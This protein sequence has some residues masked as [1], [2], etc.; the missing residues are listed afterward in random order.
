MKIDHIGNCIIDLEDVVDHLMAGGNLSAVSNR[1]LDFNT[2]EYNN[3]VSSKDKDQWR[4]RSVKSYDSESEMDSVCRD[5]W[6]VPDNYLD[7][8]IESYIYNLC[9]TEAEVYRV[10]QELELFKSRDLLIVLKALK[11][12]VDVMRQHRI[13]WGVGRGSS[14]ASY[15]LYLLEVHSID[16]IKYNLDFA[17]FLD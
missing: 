2:S 3:L 5:Q 7:M 6:T 9:E 16:S 15:C 4:L 17:E 12:L 1:M 8:D 10:Q 11:Y 14:V 13:I